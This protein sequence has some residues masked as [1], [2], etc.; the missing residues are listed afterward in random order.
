MEKLFLPLSLEEGT[1]KN[2][3]KI[4]SY[5]NVTPGWEIFDQVDVTSSKT[6]GATV[7][8]LITKE[9][10][11]QLESSS[12]IGDPDVIRLYTLDADDWIITDSLELY[13]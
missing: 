8:K 10:F 7:C 13:P 5:S 1:S 9:K 6:P 12:T 4:F 3:V 2:Q 11:I